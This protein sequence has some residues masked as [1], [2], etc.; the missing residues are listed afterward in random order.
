MVEQV[1]VENQQ[2]PEPPKEAPPS[3]GTTITGNGPGM[4]GLSYGSGNGFGIGN[5]HGTG[6]GGSKYGFYAS[7]VQNK[8]AEAVRTNPKTRHAQ[9]TVVVRIWVDSTGRVTK[10][11]VPSSG[12]PNVDK[13]LQDEV[14]NG[15]QLPEPPPSD[16]PMPIVMRLSARRPQ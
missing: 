13:A 5:G 14:L 9:M 2:K 7:E 8:I 1:P 10:A 6:T 12:D 11:R 15:L 16:M 3:L 4:G